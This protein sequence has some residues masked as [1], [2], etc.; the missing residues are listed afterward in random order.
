[1]NQQDP[2]FIIVNPNAIIHLLTN[3]GKESVAH[4]FPAL[5][6]QNEEIFT[7]HGK[8]QATDT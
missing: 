1:M 4:Q 8:E 7:V 5:A 2:L 6:L 3:A